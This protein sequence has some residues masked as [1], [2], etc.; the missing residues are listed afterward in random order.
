MKEEDFK[1]V[2]EFEKDFANQRPNI[3]R[4][5]QFTF[6]IRWQQIQRFTKSV[7]CRFEFHPNILKLNFSILVKNFTLR[8]S[9]SR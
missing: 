6:L 5:C 7:C 1:A 8:G 9:L 4:T 2:K 3:R